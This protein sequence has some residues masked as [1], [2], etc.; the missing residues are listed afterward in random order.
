MVGAGGGAGGDPASQESACP[1]QEAGA[2]QHKAIDTIH[3]SEVDNARA[4][5]VFRKAVNQDP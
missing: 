2:T 1:L 3:D 4:A 5:D